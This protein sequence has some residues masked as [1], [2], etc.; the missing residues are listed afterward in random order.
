MVSA[1]YIND[2]PLSPD[3]E[4]EIHLAIRFNSRN[5][6]IFCKR[7]FIPGN[8]YYDGVERC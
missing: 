1:Y 4:K 7:I 6:L 2:D 8:P 3:Y 5:E